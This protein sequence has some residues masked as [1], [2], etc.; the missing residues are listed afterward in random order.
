MPLEIFFALI[1][2]G[3]ILMAIF[4]LVVLR[5]TLTRRLKQ[6]LETNNN[7]WK[8][9]TLDFGFLNTYIFAYACTLPFVS[10]SRNFQRIYNSLDVKA[11]ATQFE[12][13]IAYAML[14]GFSAFFVATPLFYLI[15]S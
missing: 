10:K 12:K 14:A 13:V 6:H 1:A 15:K 3:G 9:G 11:F 2:V 8:S 7:Y 5:F 4:C